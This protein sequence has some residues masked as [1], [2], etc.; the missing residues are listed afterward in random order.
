MTYIIEF[1]KLSNDTNFIFIASILKISF[2]SLYN[3]YNN[4]S[5]IGLKLDFFVFKG[6]KFITNLC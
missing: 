5:I 3:Y 6:V 4:I 2:S 1:T